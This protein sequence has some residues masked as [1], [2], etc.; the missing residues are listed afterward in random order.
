[1]VLTSATVTRVRDP[2]NVLGRDGSPGDRPCG[3]SEEPIDCQKEAV[4]TARARR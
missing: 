4:P 3:S 2:S 1:V